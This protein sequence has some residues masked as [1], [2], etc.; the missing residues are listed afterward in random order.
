MR[1]LIQRVTEAYVMIGEQRH[2]EVG[3]CL[4]ILVG[5]TAEDTEQDALWLVRKILHMRLFTDDEGK[6]NKSILDVQGKLL[7]VSQFTLYAS[8]KKGNRPSFI[9]AA[10]PA[11]AVPLYEFF[12]KACNDLV[13]TRSGVFGADMKVSLV[14]DGPVTIWLDS[15]HRE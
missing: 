11:I 13:E 10:K 1:A 6:M 2:A 7:V 4:V 14:N 3:E 9:N 12:L 5:I 15:K 8:T